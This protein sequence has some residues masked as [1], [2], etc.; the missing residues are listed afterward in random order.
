VGNI[1]DPRNAV[2]DRSDVRRAAHSFERALAVQ[3]V[4]SPSPSR[5][6]AAGLREAAR[7]GNSSCAAYRKSAL[8]IAVGRWPVGSSSSGRAWERP[9]PPARRRDP[10]TGGSTVSKSEEK[11]WASVQ[12]IRTCG[13]ASAISRARCLYISTIFFPPVTNRPR[14]GLACNCTLGVG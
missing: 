9:G 1:P 6:P 4:G 3:Q 8:R 12:R 10:Y 2:D 14:I 11:R 13:H 7:L 5:R